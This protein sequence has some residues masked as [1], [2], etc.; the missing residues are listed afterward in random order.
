MNGATVRTDLDANERFYGKRL[1]GPEVALQGLADTR[2]P[3]PE[4]I[5]TLTRYSK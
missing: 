2:L 1:E 4:W 3:V 5:D